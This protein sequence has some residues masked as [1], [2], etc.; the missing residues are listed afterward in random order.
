MTV[1]VQ[2]E[3]PSTQIGLRLETPSGYK[4]RLAEDE[5]ITSNVISDIEIS[6][7]MPGGYKEM[8]FTLGRD[9]QDAWR[10]MVPFTDGTAYIPGVGVVFQGALDK[11]PGVSG[12]QNSLT[13]SFLGYQSILEDNQAAQIGFIDGDLSKWGDPSMSRR[14]GLR[15]AGWN[16]APQ[17]LVG[18]KDADG[19]VAAGILFD[20]T[21]VDRVAG[22]GPVGTEAWYYGDGAEIG[23]LMYDFFGDNTGSFSEFTLISSDDLTSVYNGS[24][25]YNTV[26]AANEIL[27]AS[28]SGRKYAAIQVAYVGTFVGQM[29]NIHSWRN[30]KVIGNHGLTPLGTWPNIGFSSKQ[31][32]EYAIPKIASPLT[33]DP[34]YVDDDGYIV[35][36]AWY[37]EPTGSAEVI[38]DFLKYGWYDWFVYHN[39]RFELRQPGSYGRYWKAYTAPSQLNEVGLDSQRLWRSI[40]VTYQDVDGSV[41]TV[42]PIG[43]GCNVESAELEINDPN[44]PAVQAG[45]TRKDV[46]DLQGVG[47]PSTAIAVGKRFLEEANLINRSGSATLAGYVMDQYGVMWPSVCV[48][49]GDWISFVDASDTS[50]RKIVGT[51]YRHS[52]VSNEID[53]DAP[54]SGLEAL[55]ERLQAGLIS[56][57]V[58]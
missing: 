7:E 35:P 46:L 30:M 20:Y 6:T 45:R 15:N 37:G 29:T 1:A 11:A 23:L 24:K 42:G 31:M 40:I 50:Y 52:E 8:N 54:E 12:E 14:L 10:D 47:V 16:M 27:K 9:P 13:P 53:L 38:K 5:P 2:Q 33:I 36:Q 56:L 49:S 28:G 4:N 21:G 34:N 48:K 17:V 51:T 3:L 55:L 43:S 18:W 32:L 41:R 19:T 44:H 22:S 57:G 26:S 25:N 58:S 39:K